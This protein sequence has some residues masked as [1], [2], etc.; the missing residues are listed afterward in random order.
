MTSPKYTFEVATPEHASEL[1]RTMRPEDRAEVWASDGHTPEEAI[2][3]A[4]AASSEAWAGLVDGRV[5]CL[6]GV[7]KLT[8][9]GDAAS[10]WLL[11]STEIPRHFRHFLR[12]GRVVVKTWKERYPVLVNFTDSRYSA[13]VRWL[14]WLGF[15]IHPAAPHGP[16]GVPFHRITIGD[17]NV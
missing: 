3:S 13:A 9:L 12:A 5:I 4:L 8:F 1:A 15:T 6:F 17:L 14:S 16:F 7:S 11:G 10:P 2:Q